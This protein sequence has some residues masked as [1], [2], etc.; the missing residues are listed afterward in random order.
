MCPIKEGSVERC[1]DSSRY[2]VLKIQNAS[3]RHA[4]VG[5][6]FNE[7]EEAFDFNVAMQ[8][9][10]KDKA[11]TERLRTRGKE[12]EEEDGREGG[13]PKVDLSLKEGE[14][15]TIRLPTRE[16]G[17][18]ATTGGERKKRVTGGGGGITS[19]GGLLPPPP[20]SSWGGLLAPPASVSSAP[21]V[22]RAQT[23]AAAH[24]DCLAGSGTR[25]TATTGWKDGDAVASPPP[26]APLGSSFASSSSS[27]SS[28]AT[29]KDDFGG[30]MAPV[31][32]S[33]SLT[34]TFSAFSSTGSDSVDVGGAAPCSKSATGP[35]SA[36]PS[37]FDSLSALG[38]GLPGMTSGNSNSSKSSDP[39]ADLL[40]FR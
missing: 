10:E 21:A 5:V 30:F 6:A 19:G 13:G 1:V 18:G 20:G 32:S 37:P 40:P 12:S 22:R 27:S 29:S 15:L 11:R 36:K 31:K 26:F 14:K 9:Y 35:E 38:A 28:S 34:P 25:V 17:V 39:F 3:G 7:R 8:E 23:G 4:F 2:F 24:D 33:L 16:G